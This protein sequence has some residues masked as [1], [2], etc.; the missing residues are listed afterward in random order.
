M[1]AY[2]NCRIYIWEL[3]LI[4]EIQLFDEKLFLTIQFNSAT[5]YSNGLLNTK[6]EM[7]KFKLREQE[8]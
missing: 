5:K 2:S 7:G 6:R 3:V 1:Y 8:V 4:S